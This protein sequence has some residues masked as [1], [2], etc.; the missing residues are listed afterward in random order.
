MAAL[1]QAMRDN[2]DRIRRTDM[3]APVNGIV[4]SPHVTTLGQVIQP[5]SSAVEIVPIDETLQV[6]ARCVHRT[7]RSSGPALTP[8]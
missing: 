8:W 4:K 5:G 3:P 7:S 6:E 1:S 2:E